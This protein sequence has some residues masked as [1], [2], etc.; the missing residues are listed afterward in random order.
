MGAR[1]GREHG[2]R[3]TGVYRLNPRG[4]LRPGHTNSVIAA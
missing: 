3:E 2:S 1:I 4:I